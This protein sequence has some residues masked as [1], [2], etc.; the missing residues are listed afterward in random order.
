MQSKSSTH[1]SL[2]LNEAKHISEVITTALPYIQRYKDKLIVVKYGGNAMT[3]P[4]LESSF[5]R[6]IVLLK[7]VGIHPVVVHGGGP[8]VDNLM[9]ELGRESDRIDG[10]R[11]TDKATMD[12]VEM[13][14]GGSVNKSIVNLINKHGGQAIGLTG[15]DANLIKATKLII[16]DKDGTPID[17][18][19]VGQV[20]HVNTGVINMLIQSDFIP[21]IAPLGVDEH[22]ETYNINAD[23][24]ASR[25]AECLSAERLLLLTNIKGVLDKDGNVLT[26]L[27]PTDVDNLIADGTISGGMIPKIAGALDAVRAGLRSATIVDGRVPHACLLEIFTEE[28]VGTQILRETNG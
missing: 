9:S 17:L 26:S 2:T 4:V 5:A 24:V 19:F 21:V 20:A 15:K 27:S 18:G 13:V 8:Q 22:G 6:D 11:V 28:G 1:Q 7:T 16:N 23:L 12:V 10:M 25:V 14:L 3:D